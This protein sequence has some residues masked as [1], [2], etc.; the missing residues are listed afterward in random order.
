MGTET[1]YAMPR[2]LENEG[3]E[4]KY[5]AMN[6]SGDLVAI[7]E[8]GSADEALNKARALNPD[9]ASVDERPEVE[10]REQH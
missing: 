2:R 9:A 4:M 5:N 6:D 8:A 10:H 3:E 1:L 7:V